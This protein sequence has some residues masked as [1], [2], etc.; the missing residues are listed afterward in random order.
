MTNTDSNLNI[1]DMFVTLNNRR[2]LVLSYVSR[3][4]RG[5]ERVKDHN[6]LLD[7]VRDGSGCVCQRFFLLKKIW[8]DIT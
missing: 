5:R 6:T 2:K 8:E 1:S 4:R 7:I 3:V